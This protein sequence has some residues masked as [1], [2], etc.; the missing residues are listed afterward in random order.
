MLRGFCLDLK[1][2]LVDYSTGVG[3]DAEVKG[4]AFVDGTRAR[5][6][7]GFHAFI[8]WKKTVED[9]SDSLLDM[10]KVWFKD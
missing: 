7:L 8:P 9:S 5:E 6:A 3:E 2:R 10:E 4:M 1:D